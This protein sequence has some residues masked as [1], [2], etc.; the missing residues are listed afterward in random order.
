MKDYAGRRVLIIVQNLPVPFDRRVWLEATTLRQHGYRVSVISPR[1]KGEP[2]RCVRDGVALYRYRVPAEAHGVLGYLFEFFYCWLV[3]AFLSLVVALREGFDIIHACN[4]P[5][6]YFAL[7]A[8][9][10]P[11]GKKFVFD[12]HDLSPEMYQAKFPGRRGLLY[13]GLLWLEKM[14]FK[15]A[16]VVLATNESH[17]EI[18]MRRGGV[19]EERVYVVRSGPDFARLRQLPPEPALKEGRRHL[20]VYLGEMCPQ[21]GVDYLLRAAKILRDELGMRDVLLVLMGGGPALPQLK[22]YARELRLD[23]MVKFTGRVSDHD[24]CRYLSSADLCV[25]PDPKTEWSDRSTMNKM[26]EYMAFG[27]PIVA[28][29]LKEHRRS[30]AEA[31]AYAL[32]NDERDF[33]WHIKRLLLDE[34]LRERM[35]AI[36]RERVVAELS[37]DHTSTKLLDAYDRLSRAREQQL[38][39]PVHTACTAAPGA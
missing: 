10:K 6:T 23:G 38:T 17:K 18:A 8:L 34:P 31:A 20:V 26:L 28:F 29:D 9:Y 3:T 19:A 30:A 2:T 1:G 36:G 21:D 37:W 35:G 24:L 14:T 12:H 16:D 22:A 11:L 7:A 5:E 27:K 33:A 25:D 32:P 39:A 15:T 4:P 13:R